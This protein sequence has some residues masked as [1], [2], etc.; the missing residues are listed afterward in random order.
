[1]I[2]ILE[3]DTEKDGVRPLTEEVSDLVEKSGVKEG[4]CVLHIPHTTAGITITS[5][6]DETDFADI[7]HELRRIVPTRVDFYH[8]FDTPEDA[9]GHIKSV[10]VGC[11]MTLMIHKGKLL[12]GNSQGIFFLEFDGPRK[13]KCYISI[14]NGNGS[15]E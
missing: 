4:F 10:L 9:A 3:F 8:Q 6:W 15:C 14:L 5:K 11:N 12:L 7:K 13:R 2:H 1:M